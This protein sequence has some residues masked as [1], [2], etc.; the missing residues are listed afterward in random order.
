M[1]AFRVSRYELLSP[2]V[3]MPL[4]FTFATLM[5]I[6]GWSSW[7]TVSLQANAFT[8]ILIGV[9]SFEIGIF[10]PLYIRGRKK[11]LFAS[12]NSSLRPLELN[13]SLTTTET[14]IKYVILIVLVCA[15]IVLRVHE[16]YKIGAQLNLK[17]MDYSDLA[18][19][20]RHA[21]GAIFSSD[22]VKIGFGFSF[23]E[24]Q[25]EKV[26]VVS[27]FVS[28]CLSTYS[29]LH[30]SQKKLSFYLSLLTLFLSCSFIILSGDRARILFFFIAALLF[31]FILKIRAPHQNIK[32]FSIRLVAILFPILVVS[33]ILFY[34]SGSLIG[35]A[36]GSGFVEYVSFYFGGGIPSFQQL[37]DSDMTKMPFGYF[38]FIGVY[39]FLYKFG[40]SDVLGAYSIDWIQIGGHNSN[41][42]TMFARYHMDFGFVGIFVFS[43]LSGVFFGSVYRLAKNTRQPVLIMIFAYI[44]VNVF[45]LTRE[46]YT[47]SRFATTQ[48]FVSLILLTLISIFLTTTHKENIDFIRR[49]FHK[50]IFR[51]PAHES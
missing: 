46:E 51:S 12:T 29:A 23:I 14:S 40:F 8:I 41:I 35:R 2:G 18:A 16:T 15:A 36:P 37:L 19:Q 9:V 33:I 32:R 47:F 5:A 44:T 17:Y 24:R 21:T 42:F 26:A 20:V 7:N 39:T 45:D 10:L 49:T 50:I 43:L 30:Y 3:I 13:S 27:G 22:G 31:F 4:M 25:L 1:L 11:G 28:A 34:F 38:T 48:T 6:I